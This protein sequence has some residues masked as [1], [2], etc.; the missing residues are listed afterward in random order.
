MLARAAHLHHGE[1]PFDRAPGQCHVDH[2]V[3]RDHAVELMLDLLD[4]HGRPRRD[5]GDA[6]K[7]F[8]ALGLRD[9]KTFDVVAAAGEQPDHAREHAG[10]VLDQ[11][12]ERMRL[13]R[14]VAIFDEIGRCRLAHCRP[15]II[16]AVMGKARP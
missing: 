4:H 14:I 1:L 11:N 10:L 2:A 7:M 13:V 12:G 8:L 9:R 6:G 16:S 15:P 3:D 5:D